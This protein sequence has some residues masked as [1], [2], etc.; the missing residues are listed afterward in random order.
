VL[1][2][3]AIHWND[4][5]EKFDCESEPID[6]RTLHDVHYIFLSQEDGS[7]FAR[8]EMVDQDHWNCHL[9]NTEFFRK[10]IES[11]R[12]TSDSVGKK[13]RAKESSLRLKTDQKLIDLL[14]AEDWYVAFER[15]PIMK[16]ERV[17]TPVR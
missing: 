11:G 17:K 15:E 3:G 9:P 4:D 14:A 5:A 10:A 2:Y 1:V 6:A 8:I 13:D 7:T 12:L 16:L